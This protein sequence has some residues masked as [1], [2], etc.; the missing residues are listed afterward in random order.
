[1]GVYT[2]LC[3]KA[4]YNFEGAFAGNGKMRAVFVSNKHRG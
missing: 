2:A 1:M 3:Q 4:V